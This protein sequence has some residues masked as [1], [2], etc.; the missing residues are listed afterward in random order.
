MT[1]TRRLRCVE[2]FAGIGG[3]RIASDALGLDTICAQD[4]YHHGDRINRSYL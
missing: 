2:L 3:F 4:L 1:L